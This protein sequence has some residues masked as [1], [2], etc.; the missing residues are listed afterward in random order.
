[1]KIGDKVFNE[2][3]GKTGVILGEPYWMTSPRYDA[4]AEL[5][6]LCKVEINGVPVSCQVSDLILYD[7]PHLTEFMHVQISMRAEKY[8]GMS[9]VIVGFD[10]GSV[11]VRINGYRR[12]IRFNQSEIEPI[13]EGSDL[14]CWLD[15][16]LPVKEY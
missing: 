7:T 3:T 4:E 12:P 10:C 13:K 2:A 5:D 15:S 8:W 14:E 11:L 16:L 9:G 6:L 1:M